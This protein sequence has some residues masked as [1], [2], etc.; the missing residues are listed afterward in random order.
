[1]DFLEEV[2]R[3][4]VRKEVLDGL[5][6]LDRGRGAEDAHKHGSERCSAMFVRTCVDGEVSPQNGGRY[7]VHEREL[8]SDAEGIAF[9][10]KP[11]FVVSAL[12]KFVARETSVPVPFKTDG[13]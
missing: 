8:K 13:R 12:G 3:Q 5:Q 7:E 1:L 9:C 10:K 2:S 6:S 11:C 4:V